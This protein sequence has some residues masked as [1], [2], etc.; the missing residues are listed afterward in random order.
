RGFCSRRERQVR[1]VLI[2]ALDRQ[3]VGKVHSGCADAHA[4]LARPQW[5]QRHLFQFNRGDVVGDGA[6]EER[7]HGPA[8]FWMPVRSAVFS[9]GWVTWG[10]AR[11]P[12]RNSAVA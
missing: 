4:R 5:R 8:V 2:F 7:L 10:I 3:D 12:P 9:R 1:L 11:T 6:A